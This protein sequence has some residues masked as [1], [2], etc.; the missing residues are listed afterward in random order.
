MSTISFGFTIIFIP[1]SIL[2]L[3]SNRMTLPV[4]LGKWS[5]A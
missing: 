4:A 2:S 1:V 3:F 5:E